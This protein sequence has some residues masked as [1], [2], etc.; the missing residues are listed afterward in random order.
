MSARKA[1]NATTVSS[2]N[3]L[4][5]T[6]ELTCKAHCLSKPLKWGR[7]HGARTALPGSVKDVAF[8]PKGHRLAVSKTQSLYE[9]QPNTVLGSVFGR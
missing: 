1:Q 4:S 7:R 2:C 9:K 5:L 8:V 3:P 6:P